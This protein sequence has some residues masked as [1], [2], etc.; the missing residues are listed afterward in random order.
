[1]FKIL[2]GILENRAAVIGTLVGVG[3]L[4]LLLLFAIWWIRVK[5]TLR[6]GLEKISEAD[7]SIGIALTKRYDALTK[8]LG[9]VKG[10]AK[11]EAE[12]LIGVIQMRGGVSPKEMTI[13]EKQEFA[14]QLTR[15]V[16]GL[17]VVFEKYPELKASQHFAQFNATIINIED[18]LEAT[19]R[20]YNSNVSR[21]NQMIVSFP[22]SMVA[23]SMHLERQ[24][25]FQ[26]EEEK[27][28]D[29]KVEF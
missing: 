18:N 5:N 22:T 12:T 27:R 13:D 15:A 17:N 11:H 1:M 28:Q 14:S 10:Y 29:V 23:H 9:T 19:R 7:S 26:A 20:I 25:F 8:M 4:F 24:K 2:E 6:R 21:I 16:S 3:V